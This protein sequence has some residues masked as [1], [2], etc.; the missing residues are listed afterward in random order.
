MR[1]VAST[2]LFRPLSKKV[3][4]HKTRK[5]KA[6]PVTNAFNQ[7]LKV[8]LRGKS[9]CL[10]QSFQNVMRISTFSLRVRMNGKVNILAMSRTRSF[11]HSVLAHPACAC[12]CVRA[13]VRARARACVYIYIYI[14]THTYYIHTWRRRGIFGHCGFV[15]H[16]T[17]L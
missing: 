2:W 6:S 3:A 4:K 10:T 11:K 5:A 14:Y 17:H 12:A 9:Q 8:L 7:V 15:P 16:L 1:K 13:C